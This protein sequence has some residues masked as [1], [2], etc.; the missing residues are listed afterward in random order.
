MQSLCMWTA[1]ALPH[2][3]HPS[4]HGADATSSAL[5][6]TAPTTSLSIQ[7][8]CCWQEAFHY[9]LPAKPAKVPKPIASKAGKGKGVPSS[10]QVLAA[11][12]TS[13]TRLVYIA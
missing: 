5:H 6:S 1:A 10:K 4:R 3:H 13:S 7:G 9:D 8:V 2:C 12:P 11:S